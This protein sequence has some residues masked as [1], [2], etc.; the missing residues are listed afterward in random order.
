MNA[1]WSALAHGSR[2]FVIVGLIALL[3]LF[4][5]AGMVHAA[6]QEGRVLVR[7]VLIGLD[8]D[9]LANAQIQPSPQNP[10]QS[11]NNTDILL[12]GI[13]DDVLIGLLGNDVMLG[14][15][16]DDVLIGGTEQGTTPNS[17]VML[18]DPGDDISI[19]APG[20]GS[21]AFLGGT[22]KDALVLGVIDRDTANVPTLDPQTRLPAA[23]LTRSP[24]FCTVERVRD[25]ALGFDFLVRF[26]VRATGNLAVTIRVK[27]VEQV[28]CTLQAGGAITFADL[29]RSDPRFEVV[30]P[31]QVA[32][33]NRK[34]SRIVR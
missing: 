30:T 10:N 14:G 31:D 34:V 22:G 28:F 3:G 29:R 20:D 4:R 32:G 16:G 9:N 19:W 2:W 25:P 23:E 12:G 8:N 7:N 26:F 6:L 18:G 11:L 27:E 13:Q 21:D 1:R 5:G 33:L 24:G 17:D 15:L